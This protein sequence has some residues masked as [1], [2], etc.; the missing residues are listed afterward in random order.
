MRSVFYLFP[1]KLLINVEN[2]LNENTVRNPDYQQWFVKKPDNDNVLYID[3]CD[4]F[5]DWEPE[6]L[7]NIENFFKEKSTKYLSADISGRH[8]GIK[9]VMWLTQQLLMN[10]EGVVLDDYT[11]HLWTLK[12]IESKTKI[13]N[14]HFFDFKG[15]Y[16]ENSNK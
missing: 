5:S 3:F 4:D 11:G 1:Q 12:E 13:G 6:I 15:W 2:W 14:H 16:E 9:E 10:F 7:F 8:D